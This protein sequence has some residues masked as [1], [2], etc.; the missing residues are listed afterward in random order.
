MPGAVFQLDVAVVLEQEQRA[1]FVRRVVR[2]GD[3][4]AGGFAAAGGQRG[5]Q[6]NSHNEQCKNLFHDSQTFLCFDLFMMM[7]QKSG[8]IAATHS[9]AFQVRPDEGFVV[10]HGKPPQKNNRKAPMEPPENASSRGA[11]RSGGDLRR[12]HRNGRGKAHAH[13]AHVHRHHHNGTETSHLAFS[14]P[15]ISTCSVGWA[16]HSA[17][18]AICQVLF[19][20]FFTQTELLLF[21]RK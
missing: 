3:G 6:K 5:E 7:Y 19:Y 2:D 9:P 16:Y 13:A 15:Q 4:D 21:L 17:A 20:A 11:E 10:Q 18:R 14:S 1:G 12:T 8:S